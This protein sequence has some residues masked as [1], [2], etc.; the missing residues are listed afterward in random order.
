MNSNNNTPQD[1][2]ATLRRLVPTRPLRMFEHLKLAEQQAAK[3]H[4]LLGQSAAPAGLGW[5]MELPNITV[6]L[7][8]RWKMDGLS[9]MSTWT[10]DQW[11]I[12]VNKGNPHTRRRFTLCHELKHIL[13]ADRDKITYK[14]LNPVQ[15][16]QVADYF[17]ACV[18]MPKVWLR[19]AWTS[20]IQDPEALAGL[21]V[22]STQAMDK[23]LRYLG[24]VDDE[25]ERSIASYFRRAHDRLDWAA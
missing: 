14:G 16:E 22:V 5:L 10:D 12:G 21:F 13:D 19:R 15:R 24:F 4:N 20:G 1:I 6:V 9:G 23:R 18:L 17:A 7:Q 25:P 11:V 3:L 2:M 8:P